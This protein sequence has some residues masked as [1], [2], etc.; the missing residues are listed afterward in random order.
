MLRYIVYHNDGKYEVI[1]DDVDV[2]HL[3]YLV[4]HCRIKKFEVSL[5]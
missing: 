1:S 3:V 5:V 4:E 2:L